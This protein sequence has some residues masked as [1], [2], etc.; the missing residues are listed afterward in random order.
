VKGFFGGDKATILRGR[1][2]QLEG[3]PG[4]RRYVDSNILHIFVTG[5]LGFIGSHFVERALAAGHRVTGLYRSKRPANDA[6]LTSLSRLGA[7]LRRGDI[8]DGAA[9]GAAAA[10]AEVVCHFAG[11]FKESNADREFFE[12]VNV[13]GTS[14]VLN[15]AAR[16]GAKRFVFCSTAGIYGRNTPGVVNEDSL[17]RPWNDYESS[18]VTAEN[19]VREQ[20]AK[21]GIDYVIL[22]PSVVYGPRDDRLAKLF[23]S[24]LK[25]RFPL[26]GAGQGRRH[27][28]HVT[29]VA[30]AFLRACDQPAA[31]NAEMIIAG[32]DVM[33]LRDMLQVLAR[34]ANRRSCGPQLPLS[35]MLALAAIVEDAC[36]PFS[37]RP[38]IYRR[39]MEFYLADAA[40]DCSR[41][42][43]LLGWEPKI[44]LQEGLSLTMKAY[45]RQLSAEVAPVAQQRETA[46]RPTEM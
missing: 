17:A 30:D 32:P 16:Q 21:T 1:T 2:L 39:R 36:R 40:F 15:A 26:F 14:T 18:K 13:T 3:H 38:P 24:A 41:A 7:D 19:V 27:M 20:A 23:R 45:R 22:R 33:P 9:V 6:L 25:G 44:P 5:A 10:G 31:A 43:R 28:V 35:P 12:R 46:T 37:I 34:A 29:D 42:R 11:A 4:G 8:L